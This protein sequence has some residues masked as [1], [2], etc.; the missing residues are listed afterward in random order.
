MVNPIISFKKPKE[1][2]KKKAVL[3]TVKQYPVANL[4]YTDTPNLPDVLSQN[5]ML[6]TTDTGKVFIGTGEGI[7]MINV[8]GDI[9]QKLDELKESVYSKQEIDD[10]IEKDVNLDGIIDKL[11]TYTVERANEIIEEKTNELNAAVSSFETLRDEVHNDYMSK[12]EADGKFYTI[13]QAGNLWNK[14]VAIRDSKADA[15]NVYTKAE[16]DEIV[17]TAINAVVAQVLATITNGLSE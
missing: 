4:L 16:V 8:T 2:V 6:Y 3:G 9:E 13:T 10:F 17:A 14:I 7:K 15:S 11:N 12:E 1:K 5:A